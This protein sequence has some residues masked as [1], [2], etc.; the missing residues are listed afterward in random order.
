MKDNVLGYEGLNWVVEHSDDGFFVVTATPRMQRAIAERYRDA[1]VCVFDFPE[2]KPYYFAMLAA[3]FRDEPGKRAYFLLNVQRA[4]SD[5]AAIARF[6]FSRDMMAREKL[7]L[8]FFMTEEAA[9]RINR[10]AYDFHSYVRLFLNF[11]DDL[12]DE[13]T[14]LAPDA[15]LPDR[16]VGVAPPETDFGQPRN[17]LLAPA[18]ALRNRAKQYYDDGR[19]RDAETLLR[20][21]LDIRERLLDKEHP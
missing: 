12:P 7:N 1:D 9:Q 6:N 19:Y 11:E 8:V 18:I 10:Q 15:P 5:D 3:L 4:L 2:D 16:S 21:A 14:P 13:A 17:A 20:G